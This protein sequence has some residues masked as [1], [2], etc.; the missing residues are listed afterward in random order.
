ELDHFRRLYAIAKADQRKGVSDLGGDTHIELGL[1]EKF[2]GGRVDAFSVGRSELG[3]LGL[4]RLSERIDHP[5]AI[6]LGL[7]G[8]D[9]KDRPL[10]DAGLTGEIFL[11]EIL[12]R[13]VVAKPQ[14]V[15]ARHKRL[16]FRWR[17]YAYTVIASL[18]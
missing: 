12:L 11:A 16:R 15:D 3:S 8:F 17:E 18:Q 10:V 2:F 14:W 5:R 6:A 9:S 13:A 1:G 7:A 4:Q